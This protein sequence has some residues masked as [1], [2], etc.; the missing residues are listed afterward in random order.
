M[1]ELVNWAPVVLG[2]EKQNLTSCVLDP[3]F[4]QAPFLY[5][6]FYLPN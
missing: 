6:V 3:Q 5:F 2:L 1:S 4:E